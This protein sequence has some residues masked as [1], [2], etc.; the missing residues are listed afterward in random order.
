MLFVL[1]QYKYLVIPESRTNMKGLFYKKFQFKRARIIFIIKKV[2]LTE[3]HIVKYENTFVKTLCRHAFR[4][5]I[6]TAS[7]LRHMDRQY[8]RLLISN[9]IF[10]SVWESHPP[11]EQRIE[12]VTGQN[13]VPVPESWQSA[14]GYGA[15]NTDRVYYLVFYGTIRH[16]LSVGDLTQP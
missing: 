6:Q 16:R 13:Q 12:D 11:G 4:T 1:F 5:G 10:A 8:A 15:E 7:V 2:Y 9:L 3:E 14:E